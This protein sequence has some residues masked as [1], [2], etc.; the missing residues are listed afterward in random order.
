[1][2]VFF[3]GFCVFGSGYGAYLLATGS[4]ILATV[5]SVCVFFDSDSRCTTSLIGA[6]RAAEI[7]FN[8]YTHRQ[9]RCKR[10]LF[11]VVVTVKDHIENMHCWICVS[12]FAGRLFAKTFLLV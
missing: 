4:E 12:F 3:G 9:N 7:T 6:C 1:M 2:P 5:V 8:K 10:S 11:F